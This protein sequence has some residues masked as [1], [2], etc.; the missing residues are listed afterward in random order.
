MR[1]H[2]DYQ[3]RGFGQTILTALENRARDLGY[4]ELHLDTTVQQIAAQQLYLKNRYVLV[5]EGK[6]AGFDCLF[7]EKKLFI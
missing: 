6:L 1:V 4:T 5:R 2:P 3:R 7:Y